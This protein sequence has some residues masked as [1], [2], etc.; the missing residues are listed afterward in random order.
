MHM[1]R[2]RP[3]RTGT[4][5]ELK[6]QIY[7]SSG[8]LAREYQEINFYTHM[9]QSYEGGIVIPILDRMYPKHQEYKYSNANVAHRECIPLEMILNLPL[10]YLIYF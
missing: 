9:S 2:V 1:H 6:G 3:T 4:C 7:D 5:R 10:T 8:T